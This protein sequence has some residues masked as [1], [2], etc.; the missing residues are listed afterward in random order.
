MDDIPF[1]GDG[2]LGGNSMYKAMTFFDTAGDFFEKR[3]Y[4]VTK[5]H[6]SNDVFYLELQQTPERELEERAA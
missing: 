2:T 4:D 3:G 5:A 1:R 6:P